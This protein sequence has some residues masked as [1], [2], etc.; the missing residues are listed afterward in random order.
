M[1][2]GKKHPPTKRLSFGLTG[3]VAVVTGGASGIG[4]DCV[5]AL[6]A[7][8]ARV[9]V[10][11]VDGVQGAKLVKELNRTRAKALFV[12]TDVTQPDQVQALVASV[13]RHFGRLDFA[14]NNAGIDGARAP[15]AEYPAE[16]WDQVIAVNL[17]GVFHCLKHELDV[18]A[19][20]RR[21][22][23]VNMAS[24]AGL[25]GFVNHAAYTAAKHG[26]IGLTRT[27]ALEYARHGIRVNAICPSYT[28]TPMLER[29]ARRIPGLKARLASI[30][31][32]GRL[33]SSQ[34]VAQA[35]LYLFSDAAAFITGQT[36]VL[37]GG[38]LAG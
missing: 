38:I 30:A 19:R 20:Q 23:V 15:T 5:R 13:L 1:K 31:P 17:T 27:A 25:A 3:K 36:L 14:L 28:Q 12:P 9:V 22:V 16:V 7:A 8:G 33:C 26:V 21:G 18:M 10:A 11:D 29:V 2:A 24:V 6:A 35:V 4:R 32:L 34:E 37:D